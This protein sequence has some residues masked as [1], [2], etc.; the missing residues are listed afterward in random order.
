MTKKIA[1][2][3]ASGLVSSPESIGMSALVELVIVLPRAGYLYEEKFTPTL[4]VIVLNEDET[5]VTCEPRQLLRLSPI[6][7]DLEVYRANDIVLDKVYDPYKREHITDPDHVLDIVEDFLDYHLQ[8]T[9][10]DTVLAVISPDNTAVEWLGAIGLDDSVTLEELDVDVVRGKAI[11]HY[12]AVLGKPV[13]HSLYCDFMAMEMEDH[14][15]E[16]GPVGPQSLKQAVVLSD[17]AVCFNKAGLRLTKPVEYRTE[18]HSRNEVS[19]LLAPEFAKIFQVFMDTALFSENDKASTYSG[20]EDEDPA[21]G[22]CEPHGCGS[23]RMRFGN[24]QF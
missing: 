18:P 10:E 12:D 15:V 4:R 19:G 16:W 3:Y 1:A 5:T 14:D 6:L 23:C 24:T 22:D 2:V 7:R 17:M 9:L 8:G 20:T 13:R 11:E 21:P